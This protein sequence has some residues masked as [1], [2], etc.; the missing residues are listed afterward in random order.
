MDEIGNL[1]YEVQVQLLR[2][3]QERKIRKIGSNNDVDVDVRLLVATNEDL[4]EAVKKGDF[5]ED[6]YHRLNEFKIFVPPLR[7]RHDDI[8]YFA[9]HF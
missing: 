8:T 2:A 1:S 4:V 7:E 5:R 3:I 6:L 9:E